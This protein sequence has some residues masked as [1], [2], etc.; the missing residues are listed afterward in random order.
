MHIRAITRFWWR[1]KTRRRL[2]STWTTKPYVIKRCLLVWR[3]REQHINNWS[4]KSSRIIWPKYKSICWRIV[5]KSPGETELLRDVEETL[6]TLENIHVK[7]N[8]TKCTFRVQV[9]K[10]L[11]YYVTNEGIQPSPEKLKDLLLTTTLWILKDM[12]ALNGKITAQGRF[13][14]RSIDKGLPVYRILK[15][16]IVKKNLWWTPKV[17]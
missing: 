8:P 1:N 2:N 10:F 14:A 11:G 4:K 6:R 9:G 5:I 15:G 13:I 12:Q 16:C 17:E 3:M 7:L